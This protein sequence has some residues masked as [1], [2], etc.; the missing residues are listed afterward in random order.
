MLYLALLA[1]LAFARHGFKSLA[2]TVGSELA[3]YDPT[4]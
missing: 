1:G 4:A 2:R 3:A